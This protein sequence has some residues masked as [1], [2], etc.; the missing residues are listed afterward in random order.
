M[1]SNVFFVFSKCVNVVVVVVAVSFAGQLDSGIVFVVGLIRAM[2]HGSSTLVVHASKLSND[3]TQYA[4]HFARGVF[5]WLSPALRRTD[6]SHA[7]AADC[8]I[9]GGS[10]MTADH[11]VMVPGQ[12]CG[13]LTEMLARS[14]KKGDLIWCAEKAVPLEKVSEHWRT[15]QVVEVTLRHVGRPRR[16]TQ[17]TRMRPCAAG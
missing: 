15:T 4:K 6:R 1:Q 12:E 11:K 10:R 8:A 3:I 17:R 9:A 5:R 7:N 2:V 16:S 14:L 13:P